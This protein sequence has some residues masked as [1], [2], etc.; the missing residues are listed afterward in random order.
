MKTAFPYR[1]VCLCSHSPVVSFLD[2]VYE[3]D[4]W[5]YAMGRLNIVCQDSEYLFTVVSLKLGQGPTFVI[6]H[7]SF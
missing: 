7:G 4:C 2:D 1:G 3:A 5:C 6:L